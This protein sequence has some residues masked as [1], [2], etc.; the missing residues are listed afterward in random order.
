MDYRVHVSVVEDD[1]V[2][3][4][5][6]IS[7]LKNASGIILDN[8]YSSA[9]EVLDD[10]RILEGVILVDVQLPKLSGIG[11]VNLIKQRHPNLKPL[12]LSISTQGITVRKALQAGGCGYLNK[13]CK[14]TELI[15]A[16][17]E[18]AAG[19]F[20]LSKDAMRSLIEDLQKE[21]ETT[22]ADDAIEEKAAQL[23]PAQKKIY[24]QLLLGASSKIIAERVGVSE[25]TVNTHI[26]HIFQK[27]KV[28]SRL[29]L[30]ALI[31]SH[32]RTYKKPSHSRG[33]RSIVNLQA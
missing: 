28:D 9:E 16:I 17:F 13:P 3:R 1:R 27:F 15:F 29:E 5:Y 8:V 19:G 32:F 10:K 31:L 26:Q 24:E 6:L 18:A 2:I 33:S 22:Q 20:P 23:S 21:E 30:F 7:I 25:A 4:Q 14:P 12:F 11:L